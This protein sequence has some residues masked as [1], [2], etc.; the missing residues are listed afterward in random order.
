MS[1]WYAIGEDPVS[2]L[3]RLENALSVAN[4]M[5]D[6]LLARTAHLDGGMLPT[7]PAEGGRPPSSDPSIPDAGTHLP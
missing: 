5:I 1:R 4:R 7:S 3:D 2:R 6:V